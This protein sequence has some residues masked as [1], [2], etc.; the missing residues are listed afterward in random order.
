[1]NKITISEK[2][3]RD[4]VET[5]LR[6]KYVRDLIEG[7][8]FSAPPTRNINEIIRPFKDT[9]KYKSSFLKSFEKGLKRSS[10]FK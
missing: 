2:D 7:D 9:K 3:Y 4:L 5:K 8:L 6:Y 1:M 10:F